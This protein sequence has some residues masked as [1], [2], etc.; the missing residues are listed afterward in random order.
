MTG[1]LN[2]ENQQ[3]QDWLH[4]QTSSLQASTS[5]RPGLSSR[6][7]QTLPGMSDVGPPLQQQRQAKGV[8]APSIL[9]KQSSINSRLNTKA[10]HARVEHCRLQ[11]STACKVGSL[12]SGSAGTAGRNQTGLACK[13]GSS[14]SLNKASTAAAAQRARQS[15]SASAGT[16]SSSK[17]LDHSAEDQPLA[18]ANAPGETSQGCV[19]STAMALRK[20][21]AAPI[22]SFKRE[23]SAVSRA[24]LYRRCHVKKGL[25]R[26]GCYSQG[27]SKQGHAGEDA[28]TESQAEWYEV[29]EEF[30]RMLIPAGEYMCCSCTS[31]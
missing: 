20:G 11:R 31:A 14:G 23:Q 9:C 8:T 24:G 10:R 21:S 4:R 3:R 2:K 28:V 29:A 15:S 27:Y 19:D 26:Q 17:C 25:A 1:W 22:P 13:A 18:S 6:P 12:R 7:E 30:E 16:M 5:G